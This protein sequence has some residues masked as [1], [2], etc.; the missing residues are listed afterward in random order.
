MKKASPI[1]A[2][3]ERNI[4]QHQLCLIDFVL[5]NLRI[6]A[7]FLVSFKGENPSFTDLGLSPYL[8]CY[9]FVHTAHFF[10][11]EFGSIQGSRH[12]ENF[13]SV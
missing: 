12:V 3:Q 11:R 6:E 8:F 5:E 7:F 2:D 9:S 10:P 13:Q 1:F 4:E